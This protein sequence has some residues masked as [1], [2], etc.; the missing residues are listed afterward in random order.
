[1]DNRY[2][3]E[4]STLLELPILKH[5]DES[6]G[7]IALNANTL[8]KG[9]KGLFWALSLALMGVGG[10]LIWKYIIPPLF[11]ML[12]QVIALSATAVFLIFLVMMFPV[13]MKGL[14][15][16]TKNLHKAFQ[17]KRLRIYSIV[18]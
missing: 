15:F 13:I 9:E 14:R 6:K 8:K 18:C 12:G 1:M 5:F 16:A 4:K 2:E 10:Y 11:T 3:Q 7:E 17:I